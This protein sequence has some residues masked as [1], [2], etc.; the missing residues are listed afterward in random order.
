LEIGV[1]NGLFRFLAEKMGKKVIS[2]DFDPELK[3]DIQA[4]ILDPL[5]IESNSFEAVVSFEVFEHV[6]FK[7]LSS[8]LSEAARISS[9][10]I[11][12]SV[13]NREWHTKLLFQSDYFKM[14]F[15][16]SFPRLFKRLGLHQTYD[17]DRHYW[18]IGDK[19]ISLKT[20]KEIINT[21]GLNIYQN[22]RS[23]NNPGH[24]FFILEKI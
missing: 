3:P 16:L 12:F 1:G 5:P 13:P 17:G 24:H 10:Y 2:L 9:K 19:G 22:F 8:I 15:F 14:D 7:Y 6:P 20:I 4:S 18:H 11:I 21:T 23:F